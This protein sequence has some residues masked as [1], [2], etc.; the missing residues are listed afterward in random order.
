M[1]VEIIGNIEITR[2]GGGVT[3]W[4][5]A[6]IGDPCTIT[7]P[8]VVKEYAKDSATNQFI[9][10]YT[11]GSV[12]GSYLLYSPVGAFTNF[13]IGDSIERKTTVDPNIVVSTANIVAKYSNYLI[14]LD[15]DLTLG[16]GNDQYSGGDEILNITT[17]IKAF[18]YNWNWIENYEAKNYISK[19]DGST[20]LLEAEGLDCT[21]TSPI[22][23]IFAGSSKA[24]QTGDCTIQGAGLDTT[25][26]YGQKF[27]IIHNTRITPLMLSTWVANAKLGISPSMYLNTASPKFIY[28]IAAYYEESN[29]NR[30]ISSEFF[31]TLGNCGFYNENQNTGL[32]N[33]F[34][35]DI[36]YTSS[37][38]VVID[39][40]ELG[41]NNTTFDITLKNTVDTPFTLNT[42]ELSI[43]FFKVAELDTENKVSTRN[44]NENYVIDTCNM[45]TDAADNDG[46]TFGTGFQVFENVSA[47]FVSSSEITIS[48]TINFG[49]DALT[50]LNEMSVAQYMMYITVRDIANVTVSDDLVNV[51]TPIT[52]FFIDNTD[53]DMLILDALV[54]TEH[55]Y[56]DY[57]S[58]ELKLNT[59]IKDE[60]FASARIFIDKTGRPEEIL[61]KSIVNKVVAYNTVNGHE[62]TLDSYVQDM[63]DTLAFPILPDGTQALNLNIARPFNI[64]DAELY[65]KFIIL[66]RNTSLDS[67][68][69]YCYE[70]NFPM[71]MRWE[72]FLALAGV[73]S[74][75][76]DN[77]QMFNGYN[78]N[79]SR[80]D[81]DANWKIKYV[82]QF[83]MTKDGLPLQYEFGNDIGVKTYDINPSIS[84]ETFVNSTSTPLIN[85]STN[86]VC[87]Y[88]DTLVRVTYTFSAPP[89]PSDY[90]VYIDIEAHERNGIPDKYSLSSDFDR[91]T[92]YNI[93]KSTDASG[94]VTMSA[95]GNDLIAEC[96]VDK[97]KITGITKF[98]ISQRIYLLSGSLVARKI[99]EGGDFKITEGSDDKIIE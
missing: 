7:I 42:T 74:H 26:I 16:G 48:G 24:Y 82:L 6:N 67:T 4:A 50:V 78:N 5:N 15:A 59:Y 90:C 97:T 64:P 9:Y 33:Y 36:V 30:V 84:I 56:T 63:Q 8:V 40:I 80:F 21:V 65:K 2:F 71:I 25:L 75:F 83:N 91:S 57:T 87:G 23:M 14:Q 93:L 99:T 76:Y 27:T 31:S 96:L 81:A 34:I 66:Q 38:A 73:D 92:I 70:V 79:W 49:A 28:K 1:P 88:D 89:T 22:D 19:I 51:A 86:L 60:I 29:P 35:D 62:F 98:L 39:G 53:P 18:K 94:M 41:T 43:T 37:S 32:T 72:Y 85:G 13:F 95:S 12:A 10:N 55:P 47:T 54:F 46:E 68:N 61:I 3:D 52:E 58:G 44:M 20:H 11:G 77:T 17:Q 45:L 69:Q